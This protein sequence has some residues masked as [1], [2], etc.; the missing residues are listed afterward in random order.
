MK[1]TREITDSFNVK[2]FS[3]IPPVIR[4]SVCAEEKWV[5]EQS[6]EYDAVSVKIMNICMERYLEGRFI[7]HISLWDIVLDSFL[8]FCLY[9][10]SCVLFHIYKDCALLLHA[11]NI[12][13]VRV[14]AK[15]VIPEAKKFSSNTS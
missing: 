13:E 2:Y 14:L 10:F 3:F 9:V 6:E 1:E 8:S 7:K 11:E 5:T 15:G 4:H 12:V